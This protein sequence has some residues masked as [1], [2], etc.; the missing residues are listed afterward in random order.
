VQIERHQADDRTV[1]ICAI[2]DKLRLTVEELTD[3][4]SEARRR[5]RAIVNQSRQDNARSRPLPDNEDR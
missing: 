2:L 1:R 4:A 3:L 5:A